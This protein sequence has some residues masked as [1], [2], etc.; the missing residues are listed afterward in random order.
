MQLIKLQ[1]GGAPRIEYEMDDEDERWLQQM[2]HT[3]QIQPMMEIDHFE[4]TM[5]SFERAGCEPE[6]APEGGMDPGA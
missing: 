6:P 3:Q 1:R 5:D 2:H 4:E